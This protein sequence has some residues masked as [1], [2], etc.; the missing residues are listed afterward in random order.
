MI[1]Q[2]VLVFSSK[3][4][5]VFVNGADSLLKKPRM[6]LSYNL[7]L[8]FPVQLADCTLS[9]AEGF[10]MFSSSLMLHGVTDS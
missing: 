5:S 8:L 6:V 10:F 1:V 2:C 3:N 7:L 9:L 4:G